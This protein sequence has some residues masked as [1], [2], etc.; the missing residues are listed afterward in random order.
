LP[1]PRGLSPT[2]HGS[3]C[4]LLRPWL[5]SLWIGLVPLVDAGVARLLIEGLASP[6]GGRCP[7]LAFCFHLQL[8]H[9]DEAP[10]GALAADGPA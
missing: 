10:R 5:S 2:G 8:S 4:P 1:T 7:G 3:P 6:H 9:F